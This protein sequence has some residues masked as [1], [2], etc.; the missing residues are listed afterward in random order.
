[1]YV[2]MISHRITSVCTVGSLV[3]AVEAT[4]KQ[5]VHYARDDGM[6]TQAGLR[7][8]IMMLIYLKNNNYRYTLSS[9]IQLSRRRRRRGG[10][11]LEEEY[12][13]MWRAHGHTHSQSTVII[14]K[15]TTK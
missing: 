1:M 3:Q 5:D 9:Q 12:R 2:M 15:P 13:R 4:W 14:Y 11:Q 10:R 6:E 8:R 7:R